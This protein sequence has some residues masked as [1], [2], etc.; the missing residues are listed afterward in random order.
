MGPHL[1]L[2]SNEITLNEKGQLAI[3]LYWSDLLMSRQ[4]ENDILHTGT[5][6]NNKKIDYLGILSVAFFIV[7][8][9]VLMLNS[10]MMSAFMLTQF[11]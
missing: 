6:H 1:V 3:R 9:S 4:R 2:R 8:L 10:I 7:I 5:Q 11:C